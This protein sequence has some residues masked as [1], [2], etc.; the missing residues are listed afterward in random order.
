MPKIVPVTSLVGIIVGTVLSVT[1]FVVGSATPDVAV[2]RPVDIGVSFGPMVG[3]TV[4]DGVVER[5]VV[6]VSL[7]GS[8]VARAEVSSPDVMG[9]SIGVELTMLSLTGISV[10]AKPDGADEA[11]AGTAEGSKIEKEGRIFVDDEIADVVTSDF[12]T[13]VDSIIA[14]ADPEALGVAPPVPTSLIVGSAASEGGLGAS[15]GV[16]VGEGTVPVPGT[17]EREIPFP[18]GVEITGSE[19]VGSTSDAVSEVGTVISTGLTEVK[20]SDD[21]VVLPASVGMAFKPD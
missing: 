14:V 17:P 3:S 21:V 8:D 1:L 9:A 19:D 11:E 18:V 20:I 5:S 10:D 2:A 6:D 7:T 4:P 15:V 12:S 13:D 16:G